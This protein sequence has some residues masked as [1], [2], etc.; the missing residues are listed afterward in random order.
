MPLWV[1]AQITSDKK[2][3]LKYELLGAKKKI[4]APLKDNIEV[5]FGK[6]LPMEYAKVDV[7]PTLTP[8][9]PNFPNFSVQI[10]T[11]N[12]WLI[13]SISTDISNPGEES[14]SPSNVR[15]IQNKK[16]TGSTLIGDLIV[17]LEIPTEKQN[18]L[19]LD[20]HRVLI[21]YR[22]GNFP[23]VELRGPGAGKTTQS[24]YVP[25][26]NKDQADI[27]FSGK[28]I[29]A[30]GSKPAYSFESK[31]GYFKNLGRR[32]ALGLQG[33]MDADQESNADPDRIKAVGAFEWRNV[34]APAS[35]ILMHFDMGGEF[36]RKNKNRNLISTVEALWVLPPVRLSDT[37]PIHGAITLLAGLEAGN[38]FKNSLKPNGIGAFFR[39]KFVA[40]AYL[41]AI[42]TPL[43][44]A[45]N[46]SG[47]WQ[48]RLPSEAEIFSE[49]VKGLNNPVLSL[50][51][52]ARHYV[53]VD[54]DFMFNKAF[55]F[56]VQYRWG[57]LPPAF[58]M[59]DHKFTG[60]I[61]LQLSQ[62]D[63]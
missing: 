50:T 8:D 51:K 54:T 5:E 49:K 6:T 60:G 1:N 19:N 52:K 23:F 11:G 30:K 34:Y 40:N 53:G 42:Q 20:N 55:G 3:T 12:D 48:L 46:I 21:F 7:D 15:V 62:I 63:R 24:T 29:G 31:L 32:T 13:K 16:V 28:A 22:K 25:A 45:V 4:M 43:F 14:F 37:N 33:I 44:N 26:N 10:G 61:K 58:N 17:V 57:S 9:N 18:A 38:N 39:G 56:T 36:D 2:D 35:S 27:Y 41:V 59:V 47:E